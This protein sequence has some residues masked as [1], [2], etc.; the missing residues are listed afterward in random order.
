MPIAFNE[1]L[2]FLQRITEYMEHTYLINK[3]CSH[4]NSVERM[5]VMLAIMQLCPSNSVHRAFKK[6]ACL[7]RELAYRK[8]AYMNV[9]ISCLLECLAICSKY[10]EEVFCS[11]HSTIAEAVPFQNYCKSVAN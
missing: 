11:G 8:E 4:S 10:H 5:Q 1:P 6:A 9:L 7:C 3:A 2:S